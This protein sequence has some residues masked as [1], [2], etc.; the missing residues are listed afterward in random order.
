MSFPCA[1]L[2]LL[3]NVLI[4]SRDIDA[5]SSYFN[6]SHDP[7]KWLF[8]LQLNTNVKLK[9]PIVVKNYPNKAYYY[10]SF[11]LIRNKRN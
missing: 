5:L 1:E 6:T 7:K 3:P 10:V 8:L 9:T 4:T 2:V 11:I